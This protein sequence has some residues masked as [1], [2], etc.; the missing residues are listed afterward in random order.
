VEA[1]N[2]IEQTNETAQPYYYPPVIQKREN[3]FKPDMLDFLFALAVLAL[4]FLFSRWVLFRWQGWGV[5]VFTTAYLLTVTMYFVKKGVFTQSVEVWFWMVITWATGLSYALWDNAGFEII[6]VLFLFK[7]AVYYA[8]IASNRTILGKTSNYLLMD[9]INAIIILPFRNIINQYVSFSV[10]GKTGKLLPGLL[11]AAMATI[12]ALILVPMLARADSGGFKVILEVLGFIS[13][14]SFVEFLF[15]AF[16]AIPCAAYIYG[17]ISGAIHGKGTDIMKRE[18]MERAAAALRFLH[19]T[20]VFVVLG[21]VCV[22]YTVFILSQ[23]PYFFSAF[24]GNRPDGWLVYSLYARQGFFELCGIAAINL[25]IL[26]TSNLTCKKQRPDSLL[27]RAFNVT[28]ASIT[29]VLIT[30]AFSKM[31]LYIDAYGLTMIRLLPCVFMVLLAAVFIALIV[32]QK[33]NFSIVRFALIF[34]AVTICVL[35]LSNPDAIVV[36]YNADRYLSGTLNEFDTSILYRART[37]GIQPAIKVYERTQDE[38]LKR[39]ISTYLQRNGNFSGNN[40]H[41]RSLEQ[42]LAA[43]A[44]SASGIRLR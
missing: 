11:G 16:F 12:L 36:R 37:A 33:W 17:L 5:A 31:L 34:G 18:P 13:W 40:A 44:L 15:Y 29:L 19:P 28:L 3:S 10:P 27:L 2:S 42:Y 7:A 30:T 6:R 14:D 32:L 35:C 8:I 20:T 23:L 43:D 1:N 24:T 22:I 38:A 9:G 21:T 25:A 39:R 4:G 26:T 41:T